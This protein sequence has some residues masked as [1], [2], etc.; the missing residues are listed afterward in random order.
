[1]KRERPSQPQQAK[2]Y[3]YICCKKPGLDGKPLYRVKRNPNDEGHWVKGSE[4]KKW[5]LEV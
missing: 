4:L 5:D 1:M 2:T 3:Y